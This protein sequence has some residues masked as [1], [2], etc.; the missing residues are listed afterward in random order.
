[1]CSSTRRF[2][3]STY[4]TTA[5]PYRSCTVCHHNNARRCQVRAETDIILVRSLTFRTLSSGFSPVIP[6]ALITHEGIPVG[7][8]EFRVQVL[9]G[10][11]HFLL[12]GPGLAA[13]GVLVLSKL[14]ECVRLQSTPP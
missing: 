7:F 3:S 5:R 12:F 6:V 13:L 10:G 2:T 14:L 9:E 4:S 11:V 1:L 8:P